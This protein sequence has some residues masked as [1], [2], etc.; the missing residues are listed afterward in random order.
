MALQS[1]KGKMTSGECNLLS[2]T[3][4]KNKKVDEINVTKSR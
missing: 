4:E 1:R 2:N 3:P